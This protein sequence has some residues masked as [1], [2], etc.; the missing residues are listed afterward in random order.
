MGNGPEF[1]ICPDPL[2]EELAAISAALDQFLRQMQGDVGTP[3]GEAR[4]RWREAARPGLAPPAKPLPIALRW[5]SASR[6]TTT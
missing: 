4:S 3:P 1:E 5:H 6:L 2:P